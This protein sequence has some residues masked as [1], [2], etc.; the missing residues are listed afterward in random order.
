MPESTFNFLYSSIIKPTSSK[1]IG[2]VLSEYLHKKLWNIF[3]F[4]I[5]LV[6]VSI[7]IVKPNLLRYS[8]Q[9]VKESKFIVCYKL[10][11]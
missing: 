1:S 2:K 6:R 11:A 10:W 9:A 4:F 3:S 8:I 7:F 5:Y